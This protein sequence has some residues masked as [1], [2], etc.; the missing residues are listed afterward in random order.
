M[1]NIR[2]SLGAIA[3]TLGAFGAFAFGPA[4]NASNESTGEFYANPDG[5]MGEPVGAVNDCDEEP[6]DICSQEYVVETGEPTGNLIK[7]GER[8]P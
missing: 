8:L 2:L 1:K 7:T 6:G 5:S 4:I 3:L